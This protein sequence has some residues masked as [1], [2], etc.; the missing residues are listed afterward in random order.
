MAEKQTITIGTE[1]CILGEKIGEGGQG[2]VHKAFLGRET[3]ALKLIALKQISAF[4]KEFE[5]LQKIQHPNVVALKAWGPMEVGGISYLGILTEFIEGENLLEYS[6]RI[7][8][9][10]EKIA[11]FLVLTSAIG[12]MHKNNVYHRDL[13]PRNILVDRAG[14]PYIIDLGTDFHGNVYEWCQDNFKEDIYNNRDN[15]SDPLYQNKGASCVLRGG[16]WHSHARNCRS[17]NRRDYSPSTSLNN[18]GVRAA[19]AK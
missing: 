14:K 5:A 4:T 15:I 12:Y 1:V 9:E 7:Q 18:V 10:E 17:S 11:L 13:S 19:C 2:I 8:D 6:Q 3:F 16:Y